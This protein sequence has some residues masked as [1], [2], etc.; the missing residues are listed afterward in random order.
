MNTFSIDYHTIL[1][2]CSANGLAETAAFLMEALPP[3]WCAAYDE[4][5]GYQTEIVRFEDHGFTF[6]FHQSS[7]EHPDWKLPDDA[8]EDRVV[9]VFGLAQRAAGKRDASRMK[10]FLGGGLEPTAEGSTDKGHFMGHAQGGGLDV[11]LFPQRTKINRGWSERGKVYR[12]MERYSSLYPG[13][14][15]FSRPIYA[16]KTWRPRFVEFGLLT[17][18]RTL[19]VERFEN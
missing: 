19:W 14:F 11:N 12:K 2:E 15:C 1:S 8:V 16:D 13:T 9:S 3:E 4:M 10:G 17:K 18:Q 6:L 7:A 5:V